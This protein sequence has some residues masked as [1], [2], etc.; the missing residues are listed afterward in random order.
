[1][2][3]I[4]VVASQRDVISPFLQDPDDRQG[5]IH[6]Q[7]MHQTRVATYA[8]VSLAVSRWVKSTNL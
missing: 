5:D 3:G 1:M 8:K 7:E 2:C 4:D 6:V